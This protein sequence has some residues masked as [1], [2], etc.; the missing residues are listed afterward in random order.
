[1]LIGKITVV[2]GVLFAL[3]LILPFKTL[4]D[5]LAKVVQKLPKPLLYM[6]DGAV[7]GIVLLI[8]GYIGYQKLVIENS[9]QVEMNEIK[10]IAVLPFDNM[11]PEMDQEYF[12]D[13]LVEEIIQ[14]TGAMFKT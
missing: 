3:W 6:F 2:G 7:L 10:S 5:A 14:C 9:V 1:M 4:K 13:G 12:C 8:A 11:S